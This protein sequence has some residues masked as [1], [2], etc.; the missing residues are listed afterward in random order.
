M[1]SVPSRRY[2]ALTLTTIFVFVWILQWL[3]VKDLGG[4]D[5]LALGKAAAFLKGDAWLDG[6]VDMGDPL[7]WFMSAMAQKI[8]GYRVIGEI[9]LAVT[10]T[11]V[12]L[13]LSYDMAW[14]ASRSRLIAF[15]LLMVVMVLMIET[16]IYSYPKIFVYPL[17]GWLTWRYIEKPTFLRM[18]G[19]AVA[20]AVAFGFRHDHGL[21]VGLGASIAILI[22]HWHDGYRRMA[23]SVGRF[24]GVGIIIFLPFFVLVQINEGIVAYF[25]ERIDF[26]RQLDQEGRQSVPF[27]IDESRPSFW[28]GIMPQSPAGIAIEWTPEV[29]PRLRTHLETQHGLQGDTQPRGLDD[30]PLRE[31]GGWHSYQLLDPS[32]VNLKALVADSKVNIVDGVYGSFR[33]AYQMEA[34]AAGESL[35]VRWAEWV[36]DAERTRLE[37]QYQLV[38]ISN[39]SNVSAITLPGEPVQY[40]VQDRSEDNITALMTDR[41][42]LQ[43]QGTRPVIRPEAIGLIEIPK[44]GP[45]IGL[46]WAEQVSAEASVAAEAQYQLVNKVPNGDDGRSF[47]YEL[48]EPSRANVAQL[49]QDIRVEDTASILL[50]PRI[51]IVWVNDL[52]EESRFA[53]EAEYQLVNRRFNENENDHL[54]FDYDI[55]NTSVENVTRLVHDERVATIGRIIPAEVEGSFQV[56]GEIEDGV[57]L[58]DQDAFIGAR[59]NVLWAH[60]VVTTEQRQA[61]ETKHGLVTISAPAGMH[62]YTMVDASSARL[63]ALVSDRHVSASSGIKTEW[64]TTP[65]E[66]LLED[67]KLESDSWLM[68]WQR[69][70]SI[71][72]LAVLPKIIHAQN[73]GAWLYYVTMLLPFLVIGLLIMKAVRAQQSDGM[74]H[75]GAKML[76]LGLMTV[77]ANYALMRKMG[78]FQD[79]V[80]MAMVFSAWCLPQVFQSWVSWRQV[81]QALQTR[82]VGRILRQT[83]LVAVVTV[84]VV[85]SI[86]AT[87]SHT[88]IFNSSFWNSSGFSGGVTRMWDVSAEKFN[89]W[90][91]SPPIDGYA[92]K[93]SR[94]DR[95]LLRYFYECTAPEDRIWAMTDMYT[96][97]YYAERRVVRHMAWGNGFQHSAE[98][99]QRTIALV[100][101]SPVP[102]LVGVGGSRPLQYLEAYEDVH[103]YA[104]NRFVDSYPILQDRLHREG[105]I[106]WL[107]V[108]SRRT[109]TSTYEP[110]QLPCFR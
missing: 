104:A 95:A 72:R 73:A 69:D 83:V 10:F 17:G 24:V 60:D 37:A 52:S 106:I 98:L 103:A 42:I 43:T 84:V 101:R 76:A 64:T 33:R 105:L 45:R 9:F 91:L 100:E 58:E 107:S 22:A 96:T 13:T 36:T 62:A 74:S 1:V 54:A 86:G 108:D 41:A 90:T 75:E 68:S 3:I 89:R 50:G 81:T 28:V 2:Q 6:F 39:E 44:A 99:Q 92:P 55:T 34:G 26:A 19:L 88:G 8:V 61:L 16:K 12:A 78:A 94:G 14:E 32:D 47:F 110:L 21:Y 23:Y 71:L 109:P 48:A 63:K 56:A 79:H 46:R 67:V 97:P 49:V 27:V 77:I 11:T 53:A 57:W 80:N 102:I 70:F 66:P 65:G 93:E 82:T 20:V 51:G 5:H 85:I 38:P 59:L 31:P 87:I 29:S 40:E 30:L 35:T 15:V 4:D 25:T 7:F 18:F